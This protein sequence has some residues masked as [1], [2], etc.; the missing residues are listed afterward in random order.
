MAIAFFEALTGESIETCLGQ[1]NPEGI[2]RAHFKWE[3]LQ[4][5]VYS[6]SSLSTDS[7]ASIVDFLDNL[8]VRN[9]EFAI[10][11]PQGS[12]FL[13]KIRSDKV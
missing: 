2:S 12:A 4:K 5:A 3:V 10:T 1:P 6:L 8:M 7:A 13:E 11:L 9:P